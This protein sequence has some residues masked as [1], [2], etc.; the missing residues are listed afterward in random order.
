VRLDFPVIVGLQDT[1]KKLNTRR[2]VVVTGIDPQGD[3]VRFREESG[4]DATLAM[5]DFLRAWRPVNF[6]MLVICPADKPSWTMGVSELVARARFHERRNETARARADYENALARAPSNPGLCMALANLY[7][8]SGQDDKAEELYRSALEANPTDGHVANN[9]AYVLAEKTATL[10][11]AASLARKAAAMEPTNP[12]TLDTLGYVYL[13]QGNYIAAAATLERAHTRAGQLP[14]D[15]RNEIALH[16]ARAHF[17][18]GQIDEARLVLS[19]LLRSQPGCEVP[20]DLRGL[21]SS[22]A[23]G[24]P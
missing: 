19:N 5:D 18:N 8:R 14:V 16:L 9:L 13:K 1:W 11:E 2:T 12:T 7:R 6:W 3:V 10:D 23:T 17:Q 20:P 24:L 21:V 22:S 4:Q 15:Q